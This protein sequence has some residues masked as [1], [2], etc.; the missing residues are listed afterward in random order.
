MKEVIFIGIDVSKARLDVAMRPSGKTFSVANDGR[1]IAAL[2][3]RLQRFKPLRIVLE[4]TGGF[5]SSAAY[6]LAAAGLPA[7]VVNPRQVRNFARASGRLAKTDSI[8]AHILAHFAEALM[9]ASRA[10]PDTDARELAVFLSRRRQIVEMITAETNRLARMPQLIHRRIATHTRWLKKQLAEL[11]GEIA[12]RVRSSRVWRDKERL[13]RT[14]PGIGKV[15]V[16]TLF[17]KL[18]E[19]G[20]L[21]RRQIAALAGLAPFNRDSGEARGKR[22]VWGGRGQVRAVL[23][24]GCLTAVRKNPALKAFYERLLAAGKR[25]K[26]ALTACM[27]KLLTIL[28]AM[29]KT[30]T[31]WRPPND[32]APMIISPPPSAAART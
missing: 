14:A 15:T 28:N 26:V 3:R 4:A 10:L 32:S 25:P 18:P 11:E 13:L 16:S 19:L 20:S 31:P 2:T 23:Y 27:R 6:Q 29:I 24:M 21:S 9:P 8:D 17:A 5:E 1:G 12:R 30:E 22:T 7:A